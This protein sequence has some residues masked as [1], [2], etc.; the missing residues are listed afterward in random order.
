V[1]NNLIAGGGYINFSANGVWAGIVKGLV[2]R[3]NE[4]RDFPYSGIAVGW[5]WGYAPTSCAGNRIE[6][7]HIHHVMELI[8][9]GGGIYTLG[10]QP[11]TV[12]RAA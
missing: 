9:D 11:G 3:H 2:V 4:I 1:E 10:Q 6:F 7:N 12:I 5:C 8:Q